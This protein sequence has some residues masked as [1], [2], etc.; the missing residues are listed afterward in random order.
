MV[1]PT[2]SDRTKLLLLSGLPQTPSIWNRC[3]R[4][5][6]ALSRHLPT[7]FTTHTT[8]TTTTPSDNNKEGEE[9]GEKSTSL[10]IPSTS[11]ATTSTSSLPQQ[12]SQQ[13]QSKTKSAPDLETKK[14]EPSSSSQHQPSKIFIREK[15]Y[16]TLVSPDVSPHQRHTLSSKGSTPLV[17]MTQEN[18][19]ISSFDENET[20]LLGIIDFLS[21]YEMRKKSA[22]FFKSFLWEGETLSTVPSEYYAK[23]MHSFLAQII[24]DGEERKD[25]ERRESDEG[26]DPDSLC[27][28]IEFSNE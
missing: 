18:Y 8:T 25:M 1:V 6:N 17:A 12:G 24:L 4:G 26:G 10:T 3:S 14:V 16:L 5:T 15:D 22:H 2:G 21:S 19:K 28:D 27:D 9:G 13:E 7:I 23:R 11:C 20:F